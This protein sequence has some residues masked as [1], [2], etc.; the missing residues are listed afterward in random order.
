[1]EM[2]EVNALYDFYKEAIEKYTHHI[3]HMEEKL[4]KHDAAQEY[5]AL[6]QEIPHW[7]DGVYREKLR[8]KLSLL[9][10]A[11][12]A[13]ECYLQAPSPGLRLTYY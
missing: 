9:K 11:K 13:L 7:Q 4:A 3:A 1:M 10:V 6:R 2:S 5:I 8:L 12:A